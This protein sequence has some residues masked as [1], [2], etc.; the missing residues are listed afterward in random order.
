MARHALRDQHECF[1]LLTPLSQ[2]F[3]QSTRTALENERNLGKL[4]W[5]GW[6]I[7]QL[8]QVQRVG[9]RQNVNTFCHGHACCFDGFPVE[10]EP[11][12]C[13]VTTTGAN[14]T[15][16]LLSPCLAIRASARGDNFF[17][18]GLTPL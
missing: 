6:L 2:G 18:F 7:W 10:I 9:R 12:Q 11:Q 16:G 3:Q 4:L 8:Q 15:A 14:R 1:Y 17:F 13:C 5:V